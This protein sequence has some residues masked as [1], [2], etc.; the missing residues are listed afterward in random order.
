MNV[1][2]GVGNMAKTKLTLYVDKDISKK[3]KKI[4]KITG[5]SISSIVSDFIYRQDLENSDY[6]IS[7]KVEK[8]VGIAGSKPDE[9]YKKL[10][11]QAFEEKLK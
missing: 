1:R 3:A 7:E 8:W 5:K 11:D 4:S 6:V 10:R 9:S 2:T